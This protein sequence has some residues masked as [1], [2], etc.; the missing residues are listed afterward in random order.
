MEVLYMLYIHVA[1]SFV[2]FH[3]PP[4]F[5][6]F[7]AFASVVTFS[8]G[9][10]SISLSQSGNVICVLVEELESVS[11]YSHS[12]GVR[13]VFPDLNGTQLVFIDDKNCGF[14][15]SPANVSTY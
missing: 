12:V 6:F 15:L 7:G 2:A 10:V 5:L 13:K 14:L 3:C 8:N 9:S 1:F 4:S 11:S